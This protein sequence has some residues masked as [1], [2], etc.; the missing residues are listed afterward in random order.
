MKVFKIG[1]FEM[2]DLKIS[3]CGCDYSCGCDYFDESDY[4]GCDFGCPQHTKA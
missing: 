4:C 1:F 2:Y 3:G